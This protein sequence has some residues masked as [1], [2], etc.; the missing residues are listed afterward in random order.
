MLTYR[1]RKRDSG[2]E[3]GGLI[4][5]DRQTDRRWKG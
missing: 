5:I 3:R 1:E 4:E 2:V